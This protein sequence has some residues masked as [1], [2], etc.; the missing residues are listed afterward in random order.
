[1]SS[2]GLSLVR[3]IVD[4]LGGSIE[5]RS[6]V[7]QGTEVVVCLPLLRVP[8][9]GELL[10]TPSTATSLD[11]SEDG[12]IAILR[13]QANGK[14]VALYGFDGSPG[15]DFNKP[16]ILRKTLEQYISSWFGF[17]FIPTWSLSAHADVIIADEKD[18]PKLVDENVM[19][20]SIIAFCGSAAG[21][22]RYKAQLGKVEYLSKPIGPYRL[23]RA[24]RMCLEK[25]KKRN[26]LTPPTT[27]FSE[28]KTP[29]AE[30]E[31]LTING[32]DEHTP[33]LVQTNGVVTATVDSEN[34]QK[35]LGASSMSNMQ[36]ESAEDKHSGPDF[37]FPKQDL[38]NVMPSPIKRKPQRPGI[39]ERATEPLSKDSSHTKPTVTEPPSIVQKKV[40]EDTPAPD[41]T[42]TKRQPK[43]LLVDDNAINLRL[44]QTFI[45]IRKYTFVDS[46]ENG[47][48]AV[49]AAM[50]REDGYD[51][52]FMGTQQHP[53]RFSSP[54]L[55]QL[56]RSSF[57]AN[58]L[59]DI[60]MPVLDG[61]QAT[62]AIRDL[63]ASRRS[64]AGPDA[65]T[66]SPALVIAL[67]GLASSRDQSEAFACGVDLFMTK[68][69][70]FK[71]VGRL[72]DNWE[73]N[74]SG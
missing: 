64:L 73:A 30:F 37:P 53:I 32:E 57:L 71:E 28:N 66:A 65:E 27:P 11:R 74:G 29:T 5:I 18:L 43:V 4:M 26:G 7:G 68:P 15:E 36:D 61:F 69:V 44:L 2:L 3:S 51:I 25:S 45:K 20:S 46:A 59:L 10:S 67:T 49:D 8:E 34:A 1:M 38:L 48:L 72:L 14:S 47:Q 39:H 24:L 16:T 17:N 42:T 58:S 60:S 70:S 63:E 56:F 19:N 35:A 41:S 12:P 23:A 22:D 13:E 62:R 9:K 52:I 50:A 31:E 6:Q 40:R 21:G 54:K 55:L 33:L